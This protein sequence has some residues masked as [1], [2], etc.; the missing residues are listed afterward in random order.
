M[1]HFAKTVFLLATGLVWSTVANAATSAVDEF[2]YAGIVGRNAFALV[3]AKAIAAPP[4][5]VIVLPKITLTGITT[6]LGRRMALLTLPAVKPGEPPD[7]FIVAEGQRVND[8]EVKNIDEK[9]GVVT[10]INHGELQT[11]DFVHNGAIV[12]GVPNQPASPIQMVPRPALPPP[13]VR[14]TTLTPEEQVALIE[15]QRMK[16]QQENNPIHKILP[17]TELTSE[18]RGNN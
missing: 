15:I 12:S 4:P 14:E 16:L 1:K 11:L 8:I 10:V 9:A 2:P 6:I 13:S 5:A 17:T 7:S 18:T 3:P